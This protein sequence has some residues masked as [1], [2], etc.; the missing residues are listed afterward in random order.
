MS[1]L[2][3]HLECEV[4]EY[5]PLPETLHALMQVARD[6]AASMEGRGFDAASFRDRSGAGRN[7]SI[8]LLEYFDRIGFTRFNGEL[9]VMLQE[10][11]TP[12]TDRRRTD[13]RL[14]CAIGA[15]HG[16]S[17]DDVRRPDPL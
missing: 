8:Q 13:G 7:L 17:T 12:A 11:E 4:V 1:P 14:P 2:R 15:S 16:Q 10:S 5:V 6:T 3:A 9:R